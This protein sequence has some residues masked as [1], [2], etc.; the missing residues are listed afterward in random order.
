MPKHNPMARALRTPLY[1]TRR[2]KT[3]VEKIRQL[4]RKHR[5]RAVGSE[6]G[7]SSD[8]PG[9]FIPRSATTL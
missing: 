6:Q 1:R 9:L 7:R 2:T 5:R 3:K 8:G 4:E